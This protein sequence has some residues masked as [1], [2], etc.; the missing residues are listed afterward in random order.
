MNDLSE[1]G[2]DRI[3]QGGNLLAWEVVFEEIDGLYDEA[4][5]WASDGFVIENQEQADKLDELDKTLLKK[6]Q[7]AEAERVGE[8]KP[9]DELIDEIQSRYNPYI[10]KGK[11]KVDTARA[12]IKALLTT[13]RT[14]Q[15]RIKREAADKA[16]REAE[17]ERQRAIEAMR[18]SS[19]DLEAR[20]QAEQMVAAAEQA[21]NLAKKAGKAATTGLGLRTTWEVT[22]TDQRL[23]VGTMWKRNPQAF[24]DLAQ[25]L[26]ERTVREGVR[27]L[28]GFTITEKK[29]AR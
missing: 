15:E 16:R 10:Q 25:E 8:K 26:A 20:E 3:K 13:W 2:N 1:T 17:E 18:A 14:E 21:E 24:L 12:V 23:A 22:M 28:D 7:E 5:N 6:G 29:V 27:T 4:K 19:G 9:Y 11:G